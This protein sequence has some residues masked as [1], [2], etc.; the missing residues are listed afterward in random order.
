MKRIIYSLIVALLLAGQILSP[1][2]AQSGYICKDSY[3]VRFADSLGAIARRCQM[4]LTE[5]LAANPGIQQSTPIYPGQVLRIVPGAK[6]PAIP[7]SY[8]VL[9]GDTLSAIA[10]KFDTTV[11]ELIRVNPEILDPR[12]IYISQ[13]L[14]V[15]G[16]ISE[17]RV[18]LSADNIMPGWYLEVRAYGFPPNTDLDYRIGKAGGPYT[19]NEDVTTDEYGTASAY[20]YFPS[21]AKVGEKWEIQALTTGIDN[22][23]EAISAPITIIH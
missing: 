7:N 22:G 9:S 4:T 21:S 13:V 1:A 16:D 14:R 8:T 5:L 10:E 6:P 18:A 3:V 17:P 12:F 19:P 2:V 15:P 11:K 20:V 23:V